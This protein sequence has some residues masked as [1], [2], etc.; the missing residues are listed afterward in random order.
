M[1]LASKLRLCG[2]S[3]GKMHARTKFVHPAPIPAEKA[4]KGQLCGPEP[5]ET[6]GIGMS[7]RFL[8]S[9]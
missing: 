3:F 8:L 5:A 4:E 9:V 7:S 2:W 6:A 1:A